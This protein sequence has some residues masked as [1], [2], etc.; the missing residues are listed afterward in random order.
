MR[1]HDHGGSLAKGPPLF[2]GAVGNAKGNCQRNESTDLP[3]LGE[4]AFAVKRG[5]TYEIYVRKGVLILEVSS[6][7]GADS[8]TEFA[9]RAVKQL[10]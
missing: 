3:G 10:P 2:L 4:E 5:T 8:T 9:E 7:V 1:L 6:T